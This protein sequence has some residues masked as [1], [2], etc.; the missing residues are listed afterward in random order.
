MANQR[1]KTGIIG[2]GN[3]S[4]A[5][6]GGC[7][8]F[9]VLDIVAVADLYHPAAEAKAEKYNISQVLEVD[10]LLEHDDIELVINLTI[11]QAHAE[12]NLKAIQNG[13]HAYCE[14][15]YG[16]DFEEGKKVLAHSAA[17]QFRT[18]CAPDTFLGGGIQTCRKLIDDGAIGEPVA[19][20]AFLCGPGHEHWHPNPAFYYKNGGG[21]MLDM[22]PYY[23]TALVNL[24]GPMKRVSASTR[25]SFP[26]RTITSDGFKGDDPVV[27]VEVPT[28]YSGSIDFANGAIANVIMSFDTKHFSPYTPIQIIGSEGSLMVPDPN[29]FAGTVKLINKDHQDW[30]EIPLTHTGEVDRGIGAAD[31]AKAILTDRPHRAS[32]DLALHVLEAMCA[33]EKSSDT[34][35]HVLLESTCERPAAMPVGNQPGE[36]D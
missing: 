27:E 19:A 14:K 4:D 16:V 18:G 32:G 35:R 13:K 7:D 24:L 33:F 6:F 9:N 30:T 8:I 1:V 28:H 15:P 11:P 3:I 12:V 5:Y 36:L 26:T 20:T 34:N 29:G 22:G 2:C 25:A 10:Q 23:L 21:P 31:M 17:A